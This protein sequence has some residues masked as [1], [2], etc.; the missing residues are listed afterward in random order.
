M[1]NHALS[2]PLHSPCRARGRARSPSLGGTLPHPRTLHKAQIDADTAII[3]AKG[4]AEAIGVRG[5][6]LRENPDFIR[7]EMIQNWNGK[8]PLVVGADG[9]GANLLLQLDALPKAAPT[10]PRASGRPATPPRP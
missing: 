4:E 10:P 8:S 9:G 6:A 7:L 5:Q 2:S 3:R 1:P